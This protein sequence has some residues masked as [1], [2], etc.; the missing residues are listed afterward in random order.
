MNVPA[1]RQPTS[2]RPL[3]L[4]DAMI[5]VAATASACPVIRWIGKDFDPDESLPDLFLGLL[6]QGR[7]GAFGAVLAIL[8]LPFAVAW[9]VAVIPLQLK[10]PRPARRR[11]ARQPG[12][13]AAC[14]AVPGMMLLALGVGVIF[15]GWGRSS[16]Y[17]D[18]LEF[19]LFALAPSL[20]GATVLGS[21]MTLIVGGRWRAEA[22]WIDRL[23]RALGVYWLAMG[24]GAPFLARWIF[25]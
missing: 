10:R 2:P 9:T 13:M 16:F 17:L 19:S 3:T 23:G 21:W 15:L 8:S 7:F 1:S 18:D 24:S 20:A 4:L 25:H 6:A 5:L 22:S 14:S 12:W 11:L